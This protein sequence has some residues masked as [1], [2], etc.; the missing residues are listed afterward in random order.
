M[1]LRIL[2]VHGV[3]NHPTGGPWEGEWKD[4]IV[5]SLRTLDGSIE[6]SIDFVYFDDIYAR[7]AITPLQV[8]E[9]LGKFAQSGVTSILRQPKS[10]GD[11]IRWTA[12]MVVQWVEN[13]T[14]RNQTRQRLE[15]KITEFQPDVVCAHSLGS[16]VCYD[17]FTGSGAALIAKRRFV[18]GFANRQPLRHRKFCCRSSHRFA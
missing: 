9:A 6:P 11:Q 16:L 12:G 10:I 3:G 17:S 2:C 5:D 14:L 8:L 1:G 15:A 7:H 13:E 4:A 18:S